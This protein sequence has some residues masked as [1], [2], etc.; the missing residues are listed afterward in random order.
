MSVSP[1]LTGSSNGKDHHISMFDLDDEVIFISSLNP[2][3][4]EFVPSYRIDD[5]SDDA[6]RIDDILRTM[7]HLVGV[8]DSEQLAYAEQFSNAD[9]PDDEIATLLH[10]EDMLCDGLHKAAQKPKGVTYGR[11]RSRMKGTRDGQW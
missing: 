8:H 4:N 2:H 1:A 6:W 5:S 10:K 11:K 3:A 9:V 7:H